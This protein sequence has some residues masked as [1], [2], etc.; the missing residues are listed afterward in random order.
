MD[1]PSRLMPPSDYRFAMPDDA[2]SIEVHVWR[3]GDGGSI[4]SF[5]MLLA[6]DSALV[7][8][9]SPP[10]RETL[11]VSDGTAEVVRYTLTS[12]RYGRVLEIAVRRARVVFTSGTVIALT[13][14]G[15]QRSASLSDRLF[16]GFVL[17]LR[18][19]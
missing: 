6:A 11:A 5:E 18:E 4:E 1:V 3:R 19:E 12:H 17:G 10:L 9:I 13:A 2:G 14:R 8:Q 16:V 7:D 15:P